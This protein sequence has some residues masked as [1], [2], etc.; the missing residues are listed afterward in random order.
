M[1][2]GIIFYHFS[3]LL[4]SNQVGQ[5]S[6]TVILESSRAV[7][8]YLTYYDNRYLLF[9]STVNRS[10]TDHVN[11]DKTEQSSCLAETRV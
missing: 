6:V 9:L 1:M 3:L 7:V 2:T 8:S 10:V 4:A 11:N 5:L